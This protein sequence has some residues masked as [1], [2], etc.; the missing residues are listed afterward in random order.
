MIK[1]REIHISDWDNLKELLI[2]LV[3]EEP[4]VALELEPLIMKG[5]E[6]I[7]MF[8]K[9]D[10]GY[11]VVATNNKKVVGFCYVAVPVYY[12]PV[13]FIGIGVSKNFRRDGVGSQMFYEVAQWAV[14]EHLQYLL[15][16]IWSWNQ[17]SIS[18]FE[19]LGFVERERYPEKFKDKESSKVR[20]VKKI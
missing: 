20:M 11:F 18:F 12:R 13:A 5:P 2:D 3:N 9:G 1:L 6:W 10:L 19:H 15:A 14:K 7:R 8:P 17:S 4:P 16:D